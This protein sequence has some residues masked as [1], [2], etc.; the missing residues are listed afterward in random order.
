MALEHW[1]KGCRMQQQINDATAQQVPA[2]SVSTSD[3]LR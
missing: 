3:N 2:A 1:E